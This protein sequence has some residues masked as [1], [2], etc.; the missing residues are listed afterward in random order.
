MNALHKLLTSVHK[1]KNFF[2]GYRKSTQRKARSLM[3]CFTKT[4]AEAH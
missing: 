1:H 4:C 2:D 3:A